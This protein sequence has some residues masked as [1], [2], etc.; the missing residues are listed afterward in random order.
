MKSIRKPQ[1]PASPIVINSTSDTTREIA[2]EYNGP[3]SRPAMVMTASFA[4]KV[5]NIT[6]MCIM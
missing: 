2:T 6:L 1:N 4:S 5:R 3:K